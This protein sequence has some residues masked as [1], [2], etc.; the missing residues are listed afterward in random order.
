MKG[1]AAL[2]APV[3]LCGLLA[4]DA[5]LADDI[6]AGREAARACSICHGELGLAEVPNAPNLAGES[7]GYITH[8]LESFRSGDRRHHQMTLIAQTLT[9]DD[10]AN[11]AAWFAAI[12]VS[13]IAP[14][15][16]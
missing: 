4:A 13:A 5:G 1:N 12:E 2:A 3:L 16:N 10:I 14:E 15:I 9:D 11:L 7:K 6:H 8:Q